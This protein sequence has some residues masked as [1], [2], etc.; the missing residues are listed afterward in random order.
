MNRLRSLPSLAALVAIV[1][2][3]T[4]IR[5]QTP[6]QFAERLAGLTAVT[7]YERTLTDSLLAWLPGAARDR[8]G[9]VILT[10]GA[11]APVRLAACAVDEVGYVVGRVREDGWISL[12]RV[13]AGQPPLWD[14]MH[15]GHRMTIWTRKGPVPAV[16]AVPS[17]HL[18]RGRDGI[19]NTPFGPDDAYL[20]TGAD[21]PAALAALGVEI[22]DP[23]ALEKAPQRY[24]A[25]LLAAPEA[26]RRGACAA[27]LAAARTRPKVA[28]TVVVAFA[29]ESR[30]RHR[31]LFT[32]ANAK[33]PVA[34]T[35]LLDYPIGNRVPNLLGTVTRLQLDRIYEGT[36]V[37]T[38]S[39]AKVSELSTAITRW[40][41]G[42]VAR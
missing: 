41:A 36:Q 35:L 42:E 19:P 32:A 33:A 22:V 10:L 1:P 8:A 34:A 30:I 18:A 31:G 12:R 3:A 13:G 40:F 21:S 37:E 6:A 20:D 5:A 16:M 2:F 7:G 28:G 23:V 14:Q 17:T 15:E 24:G 27:L 4:P 25:D 39:L 29:V 9:N 38:I 26:A 11:G